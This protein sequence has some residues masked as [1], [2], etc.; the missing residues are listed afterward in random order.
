[1]YE[2]MNLAIDHNQLLLNVMEQ[3]ALRHHFKVL[4]HEK[5]YADINGSG[6]HNKWSLITNNGINL[7]APGKTP[8]T[9]LMFLTFFVN[10]IRKVFEHNDL[11]S[12]SI[13]S[14]RH[15]HH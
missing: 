12:T 4:I 9:N 3:V 14:V 5:P 10:T 7:L 11:L 15:D 8:K 13:T 1:M 6:K 2:E